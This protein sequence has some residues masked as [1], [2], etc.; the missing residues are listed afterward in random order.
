MRT[1][2]PRWGH[3]T[4][5][6]GPRL[7]GSRSHRNER[8]SRE[9]SRCVS[10]CLDAAANFE[11]VR[12][13][14]TPPRG[15]SEPSSHAEV[16]QVVGSRVTGRSPMRGL[17]PHRPPS[18]S[19]LISHVG[20]QAS[21]RARAARSVGPPCVASTCSTG[22]ASS[23]RKPSAISSRV[24]PGRSH[25]SLISRPR[26]KSTSVSP[27]ITARWLSTQCTV[28]FALCP[29]NTSAPNGRRSPDEYGRASPF[30][31]GAARRRRDCRRRPARR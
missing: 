24:T 26:P 10:A 3:Q 1:R 25:L 9:F 6:E 11:S 15:H 2:G 17:F 18:L 12:G 16:G 30:P 28:S 13:G 14:S 19:G 22:S 5:R 7:R 23:G 8:V 21:A 4:H 31:R 20:C 29:G 27:E